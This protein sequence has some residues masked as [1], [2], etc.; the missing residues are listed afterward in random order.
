MKL[1]REQENEIKVAANL[2]GMDIPYT[3]D[4]EIDPYFILAFTIGKGL[5]QVLDTQGPEAFHKT[6]GAI[7]EEVPGLSVKLVKGK[8]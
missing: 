6:L 2:S 3:K 5:G 7:I 1:T 8:K 4:G